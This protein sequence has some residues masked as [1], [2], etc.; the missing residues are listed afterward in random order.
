MSHCSSASKTDTLNSL[1]KNS[2]P[3]Y[4]RSGSEPKGSFS[5]KDCSPVNSIIDT[6]EDF[7]KRLEDLPAFKLNDISTFT[8]DVKRK[9]KNFVNPLDRLNYVKEYSKKIKTEMCKTWSLTGQCR[10]GE[11]CSFAHGEEEIRQKNHLHSNFKTKPCTAFY[12]QGFCPYGYRCQ[13]IHHEIL[14]H[15][16]LKVFYENTVKSLHPTS[17]RLS[18]VKDFVSYTDEL[19]SDQK[20]R[21]MKFGVKRPKLA[22]FKKIESVVGNQSAHEEC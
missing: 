6:S 22:I 7:S 5:T 21:K 18:K 1:K 2:T 8:I 11:T 3:F 17:E 19:Q 10:F 15:P 12:T 13:Y 9:R 16:S 4:A 20:R 14:Y